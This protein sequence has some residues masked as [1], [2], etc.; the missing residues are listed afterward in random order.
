MRPAARSS[1]AGCSRKREAG[2]ILFALDN[3]G[4]P[5][6][7]VAFKTAIDRKLGTWDVADQLAGV[8]YV[9]TLP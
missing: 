3:H 4:T 7:S 9:K 8:T 6:R 2:F 1:R 5:N